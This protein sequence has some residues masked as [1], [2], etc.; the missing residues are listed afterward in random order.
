[1]PEAG[2]VQMRRA[3]LCQFRGGVHNPGLDRG[4][5]AGN[6][7]AGVRSQDQLLPGSL[8]RFAEKN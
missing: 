8:T 6:A 2:K 4:S 1:M 5:I 7:T 3:P